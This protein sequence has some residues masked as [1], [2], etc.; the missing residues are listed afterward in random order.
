MKEEIEGVLYQAIELLNKN[1]DSS[2]ALSN[3]AITFI[4]QIAATIVLFLIIRFKFWNLVTNMIESRE[5][6]IA[7]SLKQ[8]D[9][10]IKTLEATKIQAE[11]IKNESKKIAFK[12]VE[13][14]KKTS[15]IEADLIINNAK[16]I[17]EETKE[18]AI[19]QINQERKDMQE[20]IK[21][22]IVDVAYMLAEKIVENEIDRETNKELV[23]KTI[24][25]IDYKK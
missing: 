19:Q 18:N 15:N 2:K 4:L 13:D 21:D 6:K 25:S 10:A 22:K 9:E 3:M 7:E 23:E 20:G 16:K 11:E 24:A 1:I 14:A 5:Q 17:A 12:I 8:K